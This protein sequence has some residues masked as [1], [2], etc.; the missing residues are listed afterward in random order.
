MIRTA[1][2]AASV[3]SISGASL[4]FI[5]INPAMPRAR[6]GINKRG[7][8][9]ISETFE[10]KLYA[11]TLNHLLFED[12]CLRQV[13]QLAQPIGLCLLPD[14]GS[15]QFFS[16]K[17]FRF[18]RRHCG[19]AQR[20]SVPA[21]DRSCQSQGLLPSAS[22]HCRR[23]Q[24]LALL[25]SKREF[26]ACFAKGRFRREFTSRVKLDTCQTDTISLPVRKISLFAVKE[27]P[28]NQLREF[29]HKSLFSLDNL[30]RICRK[31]AISTILRC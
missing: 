15:S 27:F 11:E 2:W 3:A 21:I 1:S 18:D 8:K 14:A 19:I 30:G 31:V 9:F 12:H 20:R 24:H 25:G 7:F 23:M 26:A 10:W 6:G 5:H 29:P 4:E 22:L 28:V 13:R 16:A 17:K